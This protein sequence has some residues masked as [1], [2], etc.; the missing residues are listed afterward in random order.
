MN[1]AISVESMRAATA[2]IVET[3]SIIRAQVYEEPDSKSM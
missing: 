3:R 2:K 1:K